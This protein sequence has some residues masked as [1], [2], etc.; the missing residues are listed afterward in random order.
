[1]RK[2]SDRIFKSIDDDFGSLLSPYTPFGEMPVKRQF[3]DSILWLRS[4]FIS[5][6]CADGREGFA[7]WLCLTQHVFAH[8]QRP[9]QILG[10]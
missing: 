3:A 5:L 2:E 9:K 10:K 7:F 6:Y 4:T 1:M 8:N